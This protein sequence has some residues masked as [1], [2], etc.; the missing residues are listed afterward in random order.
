MPKFNAKTEIDPIEYDLT[1]W[2]PVG[3]L[4]EPSQGQVEEFFSRIR[5]LQMFAGKM[6]HKAEKLAEAE[7]TDGLAEYAENLPMEEIDKYKSQ[8]APWLVEVSSNSLSE[9]MLRG[10]PYRVFGAFFKYITQE[11]NPKDATG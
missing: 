1:P 5:E 7:D 4:P 3:A 8:I 9:E 11:L 2:G 10:L 6:L